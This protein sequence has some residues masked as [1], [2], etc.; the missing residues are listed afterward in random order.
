MMHVNIDF[1]K[2]NNPDL[3]PQEPNIDTA[4]K[5]KLLLTTLLLSDRSLSSTVVLNGYIDCNMLYHVM[6]S[7][8]QYTVNPP[9]L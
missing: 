1:I 5:E 9:T 2:P 8:T 7:S 4:L 3:P 6:N